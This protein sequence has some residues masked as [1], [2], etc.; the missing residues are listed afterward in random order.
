MREVMGSDDDGDFY[1]VTHA[2]RQTTG[3]ERMGVS[4]MA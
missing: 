4:E 2:F 1:S 3:K